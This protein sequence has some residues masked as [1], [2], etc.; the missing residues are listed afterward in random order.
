MPFYVK[1]TSTA[2]VLEFTVRMERED[3]FRQ[4]SPWPSLSARLL[5]DEFDFNYLGES[6]RVD[7]QYFSPQ[8]EFIFRSYTIGG[9]GSYVFR[10]FKPVGGE[11]SENA[12][13]KHIDGAVRPPANGDTFDLTLVDKERRIRIPLRITCFDLRELPPFKWPD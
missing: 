13:M 9:L 6:F 10:L 8:Y 1:S 3:F 12:V 7:V 5:L 2:Y 11:G 4:I